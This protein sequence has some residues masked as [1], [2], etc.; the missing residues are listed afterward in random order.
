MAVDILETSCTND[1]SVIYYK[2]SERQAILPFYQTKGEFNME[3]KKAK[4]TLGMV[5]LALMSA[6]IIVMA[7]TPLGYIKTP[8]LSITL[9]TIPVAV[10]AMILGPKGGAFL[11]MVFGATSFA[12]AISGAGGMTSILFQTSP[13]GVTFLCI[14]PRVLEGFLCGVIFWLV[15]KTKYKKAAFYIAGVSCPVLNT[16]LFM[17][18]VITL[19]YQTDYIQTLVSS[20]G[21]KNPLMFVIALVGIQ[22]VIEA[23]ACGILSGTVSLTLSK[24]LKR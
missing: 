1:Y 19:F 8:V 12:Q 2:L 15:R 17:G 14:V 20:L 16:I 10:G 5:E 9:L 21:A 22:G 6:I 4:G 11:G 23:L 24:A 7:L 18:T 13:I 3:N